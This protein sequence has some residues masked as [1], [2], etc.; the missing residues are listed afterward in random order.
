MMFDLNQF[1]LTCSDVDNSTYD[2]HA[3]TRSSKDE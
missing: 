3:Y 2:C 1:Y